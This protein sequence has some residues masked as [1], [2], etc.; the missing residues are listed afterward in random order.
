MAIPSNLNSLRQAEEQL[1]A[2]TVACV[3][4]NVDFSAHLAMTEC[5]MDLLNVF[6]LKQLETSDDGRTI[7]HLGIRVFNAFGSA[8]KL[9]ASG[10]YQNA[11]MLLRDIVE[12]TFLVD[13]FSIFPAK[14]S[15]WRL[16][17]QTP[18]G[19]QQFK[20]AAIRAALDKHAGKG[21]S[22]RGDVYS[23]FSSLGGHASI[24]GFAM[25]RPKGNDSVLGPYFDPTALRA[26]LEEHGKWSAMAGV[27][28]APFVSLTTEPAISVARRFFV[29]TMEYS[30]H[31]LGRKYSTE[32]RAEFGRL[33]DAAGR[34]SMKR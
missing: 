15:A 8:W 1:R 3:E 25:L 31:Y 9:A 32:E 11:T 10:Y 23:M 13:Y 18:K 16:V 5:T 26:L 29:E 27:T 22:R 28:F 4:A 21:K 30:G 6:V 24:T 7:Q 17:D 20:P 19:W 2:K 12:T 14:V 34:A 33:F